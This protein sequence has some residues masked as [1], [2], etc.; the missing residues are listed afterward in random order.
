ME[1]ADPDISAFTDSR[2]GKLGSLSLG[3]RID[4]GEILAT[5]GLGTPGKPPKSFIL[6]SLAINYPYFSGVAEAEGAEAEGDEPNAE[7]AP[8]SS[9]EAADIYDSLCVLLAALMAA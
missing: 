6:G 9:V 3:V 1:A 8:P 4:V 2:L 7:A 5:P